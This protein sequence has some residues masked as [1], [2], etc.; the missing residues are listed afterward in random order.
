MNV[1][2]TSAGRRNYLLRYFQ[3]ALNG[4][5]WVIA[6]DASADAPALQEADAAFTVPRIDSPSYIDRLIEICS[7]CEVRLLVPL[8][9]LEVPIK[10]EQRDEFLAVGTVPL[11]SSP[12]LVNLCFDKWETYRFLTMMGIPAPLTFCSLEDAFSSLARNDIAYPLVVK[13][14][15]GTASIGIEYV[16][17]DDELVS[18]YSLVKSKVRR[19][20]VAA[21]SSRDPGRDV[22]VQQ[23]LEGTEY[24]LDVISDLGGKHV[25]TFV[26]EK[27]SMRAGETDKAMTVEHPAASSM[28]ERLAAVLNHRGFLDCDIIEGETGLYV[29]EINP[30]FGGGYPFSHMAGANIP[31]ALLAWVAGKAANP[32]WLSIQVGV[33]SAKCDRLVRV[34][35]QRTG[36]RKCVS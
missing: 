15:W 24:G 14:R 22:L 34:W 33:V 1:L 3:E 26:K 5:G 10:A 20:I 31:A 13:P 12:E 16:N 29:L 23:F 18:A 35:A 30:R 17:D 8:N 4:A 2:L 36:N 25:A 11:I 28:A 9:D 32:D 19:S 7:D 6:V 27:L 21:V